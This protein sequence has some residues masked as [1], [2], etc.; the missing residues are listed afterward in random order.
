MKTYMPSPTKRQSFRYERKYLVEELIPAQVQALIRCHPLLF[1]EPYP[2]R[3]VNNFYLDTPDMQNYYANVHGVSDRRKVRLRWYG[4]LMGLLKQPVL[5]LKI[6]QGL[7]GTKEHYS[8]PSFQLLPGFSQNAFYQLEKNAPLPS[9]I[10]NLLRD[11]QLVLMN[12]YWRR[13]Y[14]SRDGYFRLTLD[15]K[16]TYYRVDRLYNTFTHQQL[17]H[18]QQVLELK[19]DPEHDSLA[20]R[21][22]SFLP[23]RLTRNSKYV[24]GIERVYF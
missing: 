23:F 7:V 6:K 24:Q 22:A 15:S 11:Q 21:A 10:H 13:Y 19:Y 17:N 20:S 14:L 9:P 4:E 1:H 18:N 12:R 5:E 2:P 16:L 8:F 3:W